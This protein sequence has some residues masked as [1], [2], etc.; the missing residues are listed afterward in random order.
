MHE[1]VWAFFTFLTSHS[2][3][4]WGLSG[5]NPPA[6]AGDTGSVP[7]SETSPGE[8]KW[9]PT[10]VFLLGKSHGQRSLV[11][12]HPWGRKRVRHDLATK[13][14][15]PPPACAYIP[16]FILTGKAAYFSFVC[17]MP[18]PLP[19]SQDRAASGTFLGSLFKSIPTK[20]ILSALGQEPPFSYVS[21][22]M[23]GRILAVSAV[24]P[25]NS[26][27]VEL[28]HGGAGSVGRRLRA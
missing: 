28:L 11:G 23:I 19:H 3:L 9:Q 4:P 22:H 5:K 25:S 2:G 13:Q 12:Y 10:S 1:S 17:S 20:R 14:P 7:G 15:P 16:P 26:A 6:N 24:D 8:R 18:P 21:L 27:A